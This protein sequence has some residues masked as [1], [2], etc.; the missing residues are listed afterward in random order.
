MRD[1]TAMKI[2][3]VVLWVVVWI[4]CFGGESE[5]SEMLV[6]YHIITR[7]H[8]PEDHDLRQALL[9]FSF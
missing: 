8:K 2:Q 3:V 6:S 4:P 7:R 1:L 9:R 5:V